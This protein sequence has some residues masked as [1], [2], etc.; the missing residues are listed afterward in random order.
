MEEM[1]FDKIVAL[2]GSPGL[3]F[4]IGQRPNGLILQEVGNPSRK[5][6][7]GARQKVSVLADIAMFTEEEDVKLGDVFI[8]AKALEEKGEKL[9][10]KKDDEKS[11]KTAF[12]KVLPD[13]DKERVYISDM[14]KMF[15]WF[16]TLNGNFDFAQIN[17]KA[18]EEADDSK[19]TEKKTTKAKAKPV[20]PKNLNKKVQ[21]KSV[22]SKSSKI[23]APRKSS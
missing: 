1:E 21:N 6:A 11:I 15:G 18:E 14:K 20:A 8:A 19:S 23:S 17:A 5:F 10:S 3:Y 12:G 9:P 2:A 13:Y 16:H 4:V 22:A 7:T